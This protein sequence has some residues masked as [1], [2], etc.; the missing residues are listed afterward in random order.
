LRQ[1]GEDESLKNS[2]TSIFSSSGECATGPPYVPNGIDQ[3]VWKTTLFAL[4][5]GMNALIPPSPRRTIQK[6]S[7]LLKAFERDFNHS[8]V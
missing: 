4:I 6:G 7:N 5:N 2:S 3:F 1:R 8:G